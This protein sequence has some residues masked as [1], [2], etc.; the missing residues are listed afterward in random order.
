MSNLDTNNNT[1]IIDEKINNNDCLIEKNKY[2]TS[3]YLLS[4]ET[5]T[6]DINIQTDN[7]K[8]Y[9]HSDKKNLLN[10]IN[11]IKNKKCYL[12][13]FSTIHD[14]DFKYTKND[15]GIFFNLTILPDNILSIIEN[16]IIHYEN[17]K[18]K[19]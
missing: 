9:S 10:R 13:I 16:I 17:K 6:S 15:N 18:I 2:D 19:N 5:N 14:K 1:T 8:N 3:N 11:N 12:K 4:S 7:I